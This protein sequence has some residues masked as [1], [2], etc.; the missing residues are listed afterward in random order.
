[1]K[2]MR[3]GLRLALSFAIVLLFMGLIIGTA[4]VNMS[5]VEAKLDRIVRVNMGRLDRAAIM[6]TDIREASISIRNILFETTAEARAEQAKR[7]VE[8]REDYDR[9][10]K[11]VEELTPKDDAKAFAMIAAIRAEQVKV[12]PA[13]DKVIALALAGKRDESVLLLNGESRTGTRAWLDAIDVLMA[14]QRERAAFR[15]DEATASY[16]SALLAMSIIGG[17]AALASIILAFFITLGITKPLA[18]CVSTLEKLA[19]GDL[20]VRVAEGGRD[21]TGRLLA[22]TAAMV[23]SLCGVCGDV[24]QAVGN[25]NVGSQQMSESAQAL[26]TGASEQAAAGEEVSASM[27]QMTSAIRQNAENAQ[28]TSALANKAASS[29]REGVDSVRQTVAAMR[30]IV[31]KVSFIE[32][33]ARQTNLLALNAAIEAARA[34]ESGKGFAVVASEVRKL[35]ERSQGSASEIAELSQRSVA[36]AERTGELFEELGP[37][38]S[39]T[40]DLVQEITATTKEQETGIEQIMKA[41]SQLEIVI[42]RNASN[43]EELAASSEELASQASS[44]DDAVSFF[45]TEEESAHPAKGEIEAVAERLPAQLPAPSSDTRR[46]RKLRARDEESLPLAAGN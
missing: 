40:A 9:L 34:G 25:V 41:L 14:Y 29:A 30:E 6:S 12:R 32:E 1:M 3:I 28:A 23:E 26:S 33:I 42:Q 31:K 20:S 16:R 22:A 45:H 10:L 5:S 37:E 2:N 4:V 7:V 46:A 11:E 19:A 36:V 35:A 21:E 17:A 13:N 15:H 27:E 8:R 38:I 24:K 44:L 18:S 39:R 43:S